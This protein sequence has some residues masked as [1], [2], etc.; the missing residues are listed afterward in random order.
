MMNTYF[1]QTLKNTYWRPEAQLEWALFKDRIDN[2]VLRILAKQKANPGHY[3][4][5]KSAA[6]TRAEDK[7]DS[8]AGVDDS[9]V[10]GP[11][12]ACWPGLSVSTADDAAKAQ[13][14]R[15]SSTAL[16]LRSA[17]G[18]DEKSS[19][20]QVYGRT[21]SLQMK[22]QAEIDSEIQAIRRLDDVIVPEE[23]HAAATTCHR[24]ERR[25]QRR[26]FGQALPAPVDEVRLAGIF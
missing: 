21:A 6:A 23:H 13:K 24:R 18:D 7:S 5:K 16:G 26:N 8:M 15:L 17:P 20:C 2:L 22:L 12:S 10:L 9:S 14:I 4:R 1:S 19:R 11:Y 25:S 3:K